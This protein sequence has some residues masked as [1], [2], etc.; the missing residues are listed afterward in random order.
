MTKTQ[1][2]TIEKRVDRGAK[3]LDKQKP[4]WHRKIVFKN[5]DMSDP[6]TCIIGQLFG[7]FSDAPMSEI[8]EVSLGFN[9]SDAIADLL[10]DA[11]QEHW[12]A[13]E[14]TWKDKIRAI[15]KKARA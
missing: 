6:D 1:Q 12:D 15:R 3:W 4:E 8:Q 7:K 10:W 14:E 13:L 11:R 5:L 9:I 2:E